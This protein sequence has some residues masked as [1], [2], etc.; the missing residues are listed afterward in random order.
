MTL[1]TGLQLNTRRRGGQLPPLGVVRFL[2]MCMFVCVSSCASK[3]SPGQATACDPEC[4]ASF[5]CD[6]EARICVSDALPLFTGDRVPGRAVRIV[7]SS[8]RL[9]AVVYAPL[10]R[11]VIVSSRDLVGGAWRWR[12]LSE[13]VKSG[14]THLSLASSRDLTVV[15]WSDQRGLYHL[16]T[17]RVSTDPQQ[18][19]AWSTETIE[20]GSYTASDDFDVVLRAGEPM[21]VFR[22]SES[23]S[24]M[25]LSRTS[26][27]DGWR[28]S[29]IDDGS[30]V[31]VLKG[32]DATVREQRGQGVGKHPDGV[33]LRSGLMAV[34]YYDQDCGDL[35]LARQQSD[36]A[37]QVRVLDQG[38]REG[39]SRHLTGQWPSLAQMQGSDDLGIAY[40]DRTLGRL[41]FGHL[42]N[43]LFVRQVVDD[44]TRLTGSG[45]RVQ[46]S[47]GAFTTLSFDS[48]DRALISYFD[49]YDIDARFAVGS[50]SGEDDTSFEWEHRALFAEGATG[51]FVHHTLTTSGVLVGVMESLVD[52]E[53]GKVSELHVVEQEVVQ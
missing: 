19:L 13:D 24:L 30:D 4:P 3:C 45:Q 33:V 48:N 12:V 10:T 46:G 44:G 20:S 26:S 49:G 22:D 51:L 42:G 9:D 8:A 41:M 5:E 40:M 53:Q 32:C 38:D 7:S 27:E 31:N 23:K 35:R 6:E 14:V 21:I 16:A 17:Q 34:A 15:V 29:V 1:S 52:G 36:G 50:R 39:M 43:E 18:P 25:M 2:A 28:T 47:V 37:W 11:Q